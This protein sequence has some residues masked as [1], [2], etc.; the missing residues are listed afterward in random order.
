MEFLDLGLSNLSFRFLDKETNVELEIS[1]LILEQEKN[2]KG[3][4]IPNSNYDEVDEEI[5]R[6][7]HN[8]EEEEKQRWEQGKP[9]LIACASPLMSFL[10]EE[11]DEDLA[12]ISDRLG[13]SQAMSREDLEANK[14]QKEIDRSR[15]TELKLELGSQLESSQ[16]CT[17][18]QA[19]QVHGPSSSTSKKTESALLSLLKLRISPTP[20]IVNRLS[21]IK[22]KNTRGPSKRLTRKTPKDL[23]AD[24]LL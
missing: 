10:L 16:V 11:K 1:K 18:N 4:E 15:E 2:K 20:K 7:I 24:P 22:K 19:A 6:L 9:S 17:S 8:F 23:T 21:E 5:A 13:I 3:L 14:L 12:V